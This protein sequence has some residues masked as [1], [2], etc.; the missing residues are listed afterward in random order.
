MGP[1]PMIL[2]FWMLSFKPTFSLSSFTFIQRLFVSSSLSAIRVVS[3]TYLR[4]LIFLPAILIP[5]CASS[6]LAFM[7]YSAYKLYKQGDN[8]QPWHIP[9]LIWNQSVVPCPVLTVASWPAYR[10]LR[11]QVRWPDIL[12]SLRIF[13]FVVIHTVKDFGIVNKAEVRWQS[14][15]TCAHL[16]WKLQNYNSLLNNCRLE[17]VGS[18]QKKIPHVQGQSRSPSKMVGGAKSSLDSNPLPARDTQRAQTKLVLTRTQGPHRDWAR[19]VLEC[20]LWRYGSAVA[21]YRG[22]GSGYSR[23]G[24]GIN[25]LGGGYH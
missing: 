8:V 11:R 5:A 24:Y 23:P 25:P 18:H 16:L 17:K 9:V 2:V 4:L 3:S 13:Q 12:I 7:M 6:S 19:T 15:R 21:C 10:F 20:L 14:R 1:D 22:R